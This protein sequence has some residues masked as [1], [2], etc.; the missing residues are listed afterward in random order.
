VAVVVL[1]TAVIVPALQIE[2]VLIVEIGARREQPRRWV[3]VILSHLR[4]LRTWRMVEVM[5]FGVL[6]TLTKIADYT[7]VVP[8]TTLFMLGALVVLL[9]AIQVTFDPF[10]VW[11]RIEWAI[12][13]PDSFQT[14]LTWVRRPCERILADGTA[15]G[16]ANLPL[17]PPVIAAS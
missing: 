8:G 13:Y 3:G 7:R 5:P 4:T 15:S 16:V 10:D 9:E 17:L 14:G 11:E 2:L 1:I 6:V 12:F